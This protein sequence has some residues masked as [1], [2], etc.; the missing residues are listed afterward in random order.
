MVVDDAIVALFDCQGRQVGADCAME[1]RLVQ[2]QTEKGIDRAV[3]LI[4][5]VWGAKF[6]G[7]R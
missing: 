6:R 2:A 5:E 1:W 4:I 7:G 3:E